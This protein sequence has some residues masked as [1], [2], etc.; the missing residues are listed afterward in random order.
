MNELNCRWSLNENGM[1][2]ISVFFVF[3]YIPCFSWTTVH[4]TLEGEIL[5]IRTEHIA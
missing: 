2:I 3:N 5:F 1:A 4:I